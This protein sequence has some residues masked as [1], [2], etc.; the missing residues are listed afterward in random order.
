MKTLCIILMVFCLNAYAGISQRI[1]NDQY[2]TYGDPSSTIGHYALLQAFFEDEKRFNKF[3]V[4][5]GLQTLNIKMKNGYHTLAFDNMIPA[6]RIN[7]TYKYD[8]LGLRMTCYNY[9]PQPLKDNKRKEARYYFDLFKVI[10]QKIISWKKPR[11]FTNIDQLYKNP[12]YYQMVLI[13]SYL[14]VYSKHYLPSSQK[15][16]LSK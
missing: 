15:I 9:F 14:E 11:T 10:K 13:E 12:E 6:F 5:K 4:F 16:K 7:I 2:C 3:F 1:N 8:N